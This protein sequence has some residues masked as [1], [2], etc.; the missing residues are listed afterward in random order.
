MRLSGVLTI[1]ALVEWDGKSDGDQI[2][3]H[4]SLKL[5]CSLINVIALHSSEVYISFSES[6]YN[7]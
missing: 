5:K 6:Y 2:K 4:F 7:Y 3:I 1:M